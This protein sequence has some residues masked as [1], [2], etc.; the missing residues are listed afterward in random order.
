MS[1]GFEKYFQIAR[2]F[3]DED[4]RADRQPEFTQLD[5]EMSFAESND[6]LTLIE[7]LYYDFVKSITPDK[8]IKFPFPRISYHDAIE[9]LLSKGIHVNAVDNDGESALFCARD[10]E[11]M[12]L[13]ISHG[14]DINLRNNIGNTVLMQIC[15]RYHIEEIKFLLTVPAIDLSIRNSEDKM[16]LDLA[17]GRGFTQAADL[18]RS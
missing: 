6:I 8:K 11:T 7:K 17:V 1:A 3:R 16:G 15:Q 4:P 2:C 18:I 5:L 12:Q 10:I 13:L 9:L 14:A